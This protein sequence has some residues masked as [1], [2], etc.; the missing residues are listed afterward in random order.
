MGCSGSSSSNAA[1]A[2]STKSW[3]AT[4][5]MSPAD[6]E[7]M[8]REIYDHCDANKDGV[9]QLDEFKQFSLHMIECAS[10]LPLGNEGEDIV[11]MFERFDANKDGTLDWTE[12]WASCS[13]LQA[14]LK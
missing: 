8:V 10:G 11:A 4:A 14:K 9:L 7:K 13:P 5:E 6:F 12:I 3:K 1:D 2:K